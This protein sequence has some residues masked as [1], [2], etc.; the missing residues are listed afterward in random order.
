[1]AL[2]VSDAE[3]DA[4]GDSEGVEPGSGGPLALPLPFLGF[5][6]TLLP[7]LCVISMGKTSKIIQIL[8]Q[9]HRI[10]FDFLSNSDAF[11]DRSRLGGSFTASPL[12]GISWLSSFLP[13]AL[14]GALP[15]PL[16]FVGATDVFSTWPLPDPM[17]LLRANSAESSRIKLGTL[18]PWESELKNVHLES[19]DK[20]R[21]LAKERINDN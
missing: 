16:P 15:G 12:C 5:L 7:H 4:S 18:G 11:P 3:G 21:H 20:K 10:S 8:I 6:Q 2:G 1:M 13:F 19:K 14:P 17:E 9:N